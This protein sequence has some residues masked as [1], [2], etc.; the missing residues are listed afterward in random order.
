[1]R[2][3]AC[4]GAAKQVLSKVETHSLCELQP[5]LLKADSTPFKE[6]NKPS[7]PSVVRKMESLCVAS[8]GPQGLLSE[9][10][11]PQLGGT[12]IVS[13]S[14]PACELDQRAV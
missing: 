13:K 10:L 1:M 2:A 8:L 14:R 7:L 9:P 12:G 11:C 4:C 3:L 6:R 5:V